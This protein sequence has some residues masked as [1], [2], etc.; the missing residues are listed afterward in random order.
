[1][2]I[3]TCNSG[4]C[5]VVSGVPQGSVLGPQLFLFFIQG[6]SKLPLSEFAELF[7]FAD[8][9]VLIK[10]IFRP[11]DY[12]LLQHDVNHVSSWCANNSIGLNTNKCRT[13][14]FSYSNRQSTMPDIQ[15]EAETLQRV[16][17]HRYLGVVLQ[18]NPSV[19]SSHCN[20][21]LRRARGVF[22]V[23]RNFYAKY[24]PKSVW[25]TIYKTAIR[26]IVDYCCDIVIPN[27]YF[28][29]RLERFQ[30]LVLRSYLQCFTVPYDKALLDCNVE[31]LSS[32]RAAS[33]VVSLVKYVMC[34]NFSVPNFCVL[35][36]QLCLRRRQRG[37]A[38]RD[39]V[40]VRNFLVDTSFIPFS[41]ISPSFKKSFFY[42]AVHNYNMLRRVV[43]LDCYSFRDLRRILSWFEFDTGGFLVA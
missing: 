30:K 8:D 10:P 11:A 32:R 34:A 15:I 7:L 31:R 12:S 36:S 16:Y 4:D 22:Y 14:Q 21:I 35:S 39:L 20:I 23:F 40:L 18:S 5:D 42:R 17:E 6:M 41:T 29:N 9:S 38:G 33:T 3:G 24:A 26:S 19:W 43:D 1:M 37:D 2:V 28:S 27:A 25:L 13:M